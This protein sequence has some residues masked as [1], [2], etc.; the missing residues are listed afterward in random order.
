MGEGITRLGG[1]WRVLIAV[2]AAVVVALTGAGWSLVS[3]A[4]PPRTIRMATGPDGSDY[5]EFGRRYRDLLAA[6]GVDLQLVPTAGAGENLAKVRDPGS[7]VSVGF[8]VAGLSGKEPRGLES[9]GAVAYEPL[10]LFERAD[11]RR[12][13]DL[14]A[15]RRISVPRGTRFSIGPEGSSTRAVALQFLSL[16]GVKGGDV[17]LLALEPEE[18]VDQL[19]AGKIDAFTLAASWESPLVRKLAA[20]PKVALISFARADAYVALNPYL[21]KLVLPR[22]VADLRADLPSSDVFLVAPKTSLV[23]RSDLHPAVQYLLLQAASRIH[24]GPAIFHRTGTFPAAEAIDIPLSEE[25]TR[26]YTSGRPLL[27][28]YLPFWLWVLAERLLV[29]LVPVLTIAYPL[30]RLGPGMW[31]SMMQRRI[32]LLYGEL[33]MLETELDA[34]ASGSTTADLAQR[35]DA[36]SA[37]AGHVRVPL[38]YTWMLYTLKGHIRSVGERIAGRG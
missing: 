25:A 24:S 26:Y 19:L 17:E 12:F 35:L 6:S 15:S 37:R 18:S 33:K 31:N 14:A 3:R 29:V 27:Q 16:F 22:G 4:I 28:R 30:A 23:I 34:R 11:A 9:L 36:L 38:Q 13:A 5:A 21:T 10:W 20:S 2:A 32:I 7:G 8:T 1:A